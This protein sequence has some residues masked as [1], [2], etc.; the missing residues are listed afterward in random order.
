MRFTICFVF[1][2]PAVIAVLA[3]PPTP[4][5]QRDAAS[6]IVDAF[7]THQIVAV[8]DPHGNEQ[9]AAFRIS[10][11]RDKRFLST[12]N[13]VVVESGN[14]RYQSL[15]DQFVS[16]GDIPD[17]VLRQTWQNTTVAGFAW[18]RSIYAEFFHAVR[19]VNRSRPPD[20]RIR[21]LL[22]DPPIDWSTT[23]TAEDLLTWLRERDAFA[24]TVIRDQVLAKGHH[25]LVIYGEGHFWRHTPAAIKNIVARLSGASIFTVSTPIQADIT[26]LQS[27]AAKWAIPSLVLLRGTTVGMKEFTFFVPDSGMNTPSFRFEDQVDAMLYLGP[28]STMTTSMVPAAL[29]ADEDYVSM[30]T[31]RMAL[32][33]GP[34]G[35][36]P[37]LERLRR[38][39]ATQ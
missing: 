27:D 23:R 3:T 36:L 10:L 35:S 29:C 22:G 1:G 9:A 37:P 32:D 13:D 28:P 15:V 30:R 2:T 19:D 4:A 21:L 20:H 38:N 11:I 25:A 12:V 7:K 24:A 33:P 39:C 26:K 8:G 14:S 6:A 16:G 34:P 17:R 31:S 18:E 5:I